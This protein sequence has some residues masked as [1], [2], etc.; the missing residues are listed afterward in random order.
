MHFEHRVC[1]EPIE[2]VVNCGHRARLRGFVLHVAAADG[3]KSALHFGVGPRECVCCV[4][5]KKNTCCD[6]AGVRGLMVVA[7]NVDHKCVPPPPHCSAPAGINSLPCADVEHLEHL[8]ALQSPLKH[9]CQA[10]TRTMLNICHPARQTL[11]TL[12]LGFWEEPGPKGLCAASGPLAW[13][14]RRLPL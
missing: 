2:L 3:G 5:S 7:S 6:W 8:Y 4:S 10:P 9:P 11:A 13:A 14:L 1:G 12:G